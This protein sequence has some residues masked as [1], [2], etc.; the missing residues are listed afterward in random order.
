MAYPPCPCPRQVGREALIGQSCRPVSRSSV[1]N[2]VCVKVRARRSGSLSCECLVG[3]RECTRDARG[4]GGV[5]LS[6]SQNA[7]GW[8]LKKGYAVNGVARIKHY[9][10]VTA[11]CDA[12][13][14]GRSHV[15]VSNSRGTYQLLIVCTLPC[16]V[17]RSLSKGG[18]LT[19]RSHNV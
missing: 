5:A 11:P 10:G 19:A 4:E 7:S 18:C 2:R 12:G 3:F 13:A 15:W 14:K 6:V 16:N 1:T 17:N 9:E 8:M